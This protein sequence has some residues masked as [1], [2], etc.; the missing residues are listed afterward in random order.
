VLVHSELIQLASGYLRSE[1]ASHTLQPTA[2]VNEAYMR[3]VSIVDRDWQNRSQF[4]AMAAHLMRQV[5][6][7]HARQHRAQKRG[8]GLANLSLDESIATPGSDSRGLDLLDLHEALEHL[9]KASPRTSKALELQ[10]FGGL[11]PQEIATTLDVS[12]S[13]VA[14]ELRLGKAWIYDFIQQRSATS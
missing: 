12:L 8:G 4:F 11:S 5:L 6:V 3:M 1:R 13:T 10:A 7:D 9:E 14:R 2:L